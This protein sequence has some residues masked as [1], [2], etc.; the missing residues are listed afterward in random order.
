MSRTML[1]CDNITYKIVCCIVE[2]NTNAQR[3][4]LQAH[5]LG[6]VKLCYQTF[7]IAIP[8]LHCATVS[9]KAVINSYCNYRTMVS[10]RVATITVKGRVHKLDDVKQTLMMKWIQ[11]CKRAFPITK[12]F[13]CAY[14]DPPWA[15]QSGNYANS[16][17]L[18][19][20]ATYP[21]MSIKELIQVPVFDILT[22]PAVVFVW[23]SGSI[24]SDTLRVIEGWKLKYVTLFSVWT[25]T[26]NDGT[27]VVGPGFYARPSTE[28][29]CLCRKGNGIL[30][31]K[32]SQKIVRQ[33]VRTPR[34]RHSEKPDIFADIITSFFDVPNRIELFARKLRPGW[35][36]WGLEISAGKSK[37]FYH[38]D[39]G[40]EDPQTEEG[41]KPAKKM[42]GN[43]EIS[44]TDQYLIEEITLPRKFFVDNKLL[45]VL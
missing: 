15:F 11:E 9:V 32:R 3:C 36:A 40:Y 6:T 29:I 7:R 24:L 31:W 18:N 26:Y 1:K 35:S 10:K 45:G 20:L 21:T 23:T 19:G 27:D 43:C 39:S 28:M 37:H 2:P 38:Q 42:G 34:L 17:S 12:S 5:I 30:K 22:D 41:V 14:I 33:V 4:S 8:I 25:K 13:Q 44:P 16:R